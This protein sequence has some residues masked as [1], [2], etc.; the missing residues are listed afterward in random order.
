MIKVNNWRDYQ[1]A[2]MVITTCPVAAELEDEIKR[3]MRG[4]THRERK[5]EWYIDP[6]SDYQSMCMWAIIDVG[7]LTREEINNK[8]ESCRLTPRFSYYDCTGCWFTT[9]LRWGY[10]NANKIWVIHHT[11]C[12]V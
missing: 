3:A 8:V 2:H 6:R 11:S 4:F 10:I 5:A 1:F 9:S 12:D 7:N